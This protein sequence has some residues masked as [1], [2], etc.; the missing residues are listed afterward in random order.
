MTFCWL[1]RKDPDPDV[2]R[3]PSITTDNLGAAAARTGL[4]RRELGARLQGGLVAMEASYRTAYVRCILAAVTGIDVRSFV[5]CISWR[6]LIRN[7]QAE[8]PS[9]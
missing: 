7:I 6:P 4:V 2:M 3:S 5:Y 9:F 8:N 1:L